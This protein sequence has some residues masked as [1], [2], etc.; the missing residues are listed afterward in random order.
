VTA[1]ETP[2]SKPGGPGTD[3]KTHLWDDPRNVDRL[4]KVFYAL[5]VLLVLADIVAHRHVAHP[6]ERFFGFHAF[7]GFVACWTLVVVAKVMRK[8]LMRGEDYYDVD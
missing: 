7:Y 4:L 2:Q 6:W 5:C 3:E 8:L 1:P